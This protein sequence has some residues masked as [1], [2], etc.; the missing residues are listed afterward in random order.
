M[1]GCRNCLTPFTRASLD[2]VPTTTFC[3]D[4]LEVQQGRRDVIDTLSRHSIRRWINGDFHFFEIPTSVAR[5]TG[6]DQLLRF[7]VVQRPA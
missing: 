4:M 7:K 6:L 5:D 2:T 1:K 3:L